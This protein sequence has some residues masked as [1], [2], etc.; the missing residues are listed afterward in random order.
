[1]NQHDMNTLLEQQPL[2][3][4]EGAVVERLRRSNDIR[5]DPQLLNAPLIYSDHGRQALTG[6]YREYIDIAVRAGL[7]MLL[8]TPTWRADR[9]RILDNNCPETLNIDAARFMRS[10]RDTT[11]AE[12]GLFIGGLLGCKN[13]CYQPQQALSTEQAE[14][15]HRWQAEQLAQG[16]VD[17]LIAETLPSMHEALGLARAMQHSGLPYIISFV[18]NR[19]GCLL[20][21]H[22]LDEAFQFIDSQTDVKPLGYMVNC[23]YPSFLC[24]E[25][26]N[27]F[28]FERLLGFLANASALDHC[29]L[30]QAEDI[31]I[32][33]IEEWVEQMLQLNRRFGVRMLGG[34]CG[35]DNRHLEQLVRACQAQALTGS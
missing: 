25:H 5:I 22:R 7:P 34:C 15:F 30:D 29:D 26:Q 21:G 1:M 13:D 3:L 11:T 32:N 31:Q 14:Q 8:C 12:H 10:L 20:D 4:M 9:E 35:T 24:A 33:P 28:V 2:I 17:F 23:A 6:I 18:I 19:Q 27:E 16:G